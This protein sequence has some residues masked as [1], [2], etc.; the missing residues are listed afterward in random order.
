MANKIS[1]IASVA[2]TQ[3]NLSS[4]TQTLDYN[5]NNNSK[6]GTGVGS[7]YVGNRKRGSEHLSSNKS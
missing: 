6:Q 2:T 1:P 7:N 3:H 5:Y 4:I